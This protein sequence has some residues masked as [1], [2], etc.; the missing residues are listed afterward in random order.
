MHE[1]WVNDLIKHVSQWIPAWLQEDLFYLKD[2]NFLN[3]TIAL[4]VRSLQIE[5]D[6]WEGQN[7]LEISLMIMNNLKESVLNQ[8]GHQSLS[9]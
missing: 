1:M 9:S 3:G 8:T 6:M 7:L 5:C 2:F 4:T